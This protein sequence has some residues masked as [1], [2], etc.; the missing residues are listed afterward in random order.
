MIKLSKLPLMKW[1]AL[2][3]HLAKLVGDVVEA[4][5]DHR[6]DE[7]EAKHLGSELIAL[8]VALID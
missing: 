8:V 6:I 2:L 4:Y 1:L 3:P 5:K 7:E